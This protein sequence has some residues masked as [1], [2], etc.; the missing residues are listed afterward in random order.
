MIPVRGYKN[1]IVGVL[2]LG[3]AGL[4]TC[5]ALRMGD[6]NPICW[7]DSPE[8][9]EKAK[10][11]GFIIRDLNDRKTL[12]ELSALIVAPGIPTLYPEPHPVVKTA[13]ENGIII[14]NEIV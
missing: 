8:A 13:M 10:Q 11:E 2:G 14:D 1:C 9:C 6:A 4:A 12:S 5:K 7:D 3:K